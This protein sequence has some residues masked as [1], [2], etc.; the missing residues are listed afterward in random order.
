MCRTLS[1]ALSSYINNHN[2]FL[3]QSVIML[4]CTDRFINVK[5]AVHSRNE[6][7]LVTIHYNPFMYWWIQFASILLRIFTSM[8]LRNGSIWFSFLEKSSYFDIRAMLTS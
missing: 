2:A 8:F 5:T 3:I 1:Y 7:H 6:L 4:A